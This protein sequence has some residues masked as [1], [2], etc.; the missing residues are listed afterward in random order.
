MAQSQSN[1]HDN[2]PVVITGASTGIGAAS[3]ILLARKGFRVFAGVRREALVMLSQQ[4]VAS[5]HVNNFLD[6]L[7][8]NNRTGSIASIATVFHEEREAKAGIVPAQITTAVPLS[9]EL[10]ERARAAL[11]RA[12]GKK[13][14]LTS[15]TD[16]KLVGGAVTRMGSTVFDGSLRTQLQQ[17]R[18]KM[19]QE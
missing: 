2:R 3:A 18:N 7:V 19:I 13:V 15:T 12:T 4:F 11:E 1:D 8:R 14:R 17:L 5:E 16:P 6:T 9:D 10:K